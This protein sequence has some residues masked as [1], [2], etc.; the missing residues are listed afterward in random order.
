MKKYYYNILKIIII[1]C[2]LLIDIYLIE[3]EKYMF[4]ILLSLLHYKNQF[5]SLK[6]IIN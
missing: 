3:M 5:N 6:F 2:V 4:S 1:I